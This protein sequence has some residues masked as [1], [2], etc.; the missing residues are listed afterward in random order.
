[1]DVGYRSLGFTLGVFLIRYRPRSALNPPRGP[2]ESRKGEP[3]CLRKLRGFFVA[4]QLLIPRRLFVICK[5]FLGMKYTIQL[6]K[7]ASEEAF[8]AAVPDHIAYCQELHARGVLI[9]GG[10][11]RDGLGGMLL[12]EARDEEEA[13]AIARA[14]PFVTSGVESYAVRAWEALTP[15][16]RELLTRDGQ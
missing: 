14:D 2:T 1:M 9:A 15:V 11:F 13:H 5:E 16:N 8:R 3:R 12:I 10:P 6:T 4:K 7:T